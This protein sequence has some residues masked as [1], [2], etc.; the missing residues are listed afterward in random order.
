VGTS[1]PPNPPERSW[2]PRSDTHCGAIDVGGE[3]L[4][5]AC[6]RTQLIIMTGSLYV[7]LRG[8]G[9]SPETTP[10]G[11]SRRWS[12]RMWSSLG[13]HPIGPSLPTGA[14]ISG[15]PRLPIQVIQVR[16]LVGPVVSRSAPD[17]QRNGYMICGSDQ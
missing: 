12:R 1:G 10:R 9:S 8:R 14:F 5:R 4:W 6:G 17:G 16:T 11:S 3:A 2:Y 15:H 13:A 7:S